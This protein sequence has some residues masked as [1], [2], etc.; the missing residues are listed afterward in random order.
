M[1]FIVEFPDFTL[2]FAPFNAVQ[3][4]FCAIKTGRNYKY[5]V[6]F[7]WQDLSLK[8]SFVSSFDQMKPDY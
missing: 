3:G 1:L 5:Q 2:P 6:F 7:P 4:T 8:N